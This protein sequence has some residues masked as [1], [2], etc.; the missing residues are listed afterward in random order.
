MVTEVLTAKFMNPEKTAVRFTLTDRGESASIT[1]HES[2]NGWQM[3]NYSRAK[4][5]LSKNYTDI[6]KLEKEVKDYLRAIIRKPIDKATRKRQMINLV[7]RLS[8]QVRENELSAKDFI[9]TRAKR[10]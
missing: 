4:G 8:R 3:R 5:P 9:P 7:D 1:I 10:R 6:G 2:K